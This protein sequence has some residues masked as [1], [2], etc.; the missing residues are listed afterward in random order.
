MVVSRTF[1]GSGLVALAALALPPAVAQPLPSDPQMTCMFSKA[2]FAGM[3]ESGSVTL[4]GAVNPANS[5]VNPG[6]AGPPCPF[7]LWADQMYLWLTG[8][9]SGNSGPITLFS[10]TFYA[11]SPADSTG[12]RS[13]VRNVA[14]APVDMRL[15]TIKPPGMLP[16]VRAR[17]G[18]LIEVAPAAAGDLAAPVVRLRGGGTARLGRVA[19][20]ASG[21]L[22]YFDSRGRRVQVRV[23]ALPRTAR[24]PALLMPGGARVPVLGPAAARDAVRARRLGSGGVR[25]LVDRNNDVIEVEPGGVETEEGQASGAVLISQ[26]LVDGSKFGSLVYYLISANDAYAYHRSAQGNAPINDPTGITFPTSLADLA[27]AA[28]YARSNGLPPIADPNALALEIKSSWVEASTVPNPEDYVQIQANLPVFDMTNPNMWVLKPGQSRQATMVMVGLHVVGSTANHGEMVWASFEHFGNAPNM[29]YSYNSLSGL[30]TVPQNTVGNW[31]LAPNGWTGPFNVQRA[32]W[33]PAGATPANIS[34]SPIGFAP[35]LRLAPWGSMPG[36]GSAAMNTDIIAVNN[37]RI[38]QLAPGDV[39]R[40]YFQ[41]GA[42]WTNGGVAPSPQFN[43]VNLL[44]TTQLANTTMETFVQGPTAG[45]P[46]TAGTNCFSCH[47]QSNTSSP[48]SVAVSHVYG[49]MYPVVAA[50]RGR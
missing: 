40:N 24:R 22:Q 28:N 7:F 39:R 21:A 13:F 29:A 32:T 35:V 2:A 17:S 23:A 20:T 36:A 43:A 14:G 6:A 4:N 37:S 44:G 26:N 49:V 18:H 15:R 25:V 47:N 27:P 30:R 38:G 16:L 19:R 8:P 42:V 5:T 11:V 31:L 50:K 34:G 41:L 1:V 9:A 33:N 10:P 3:F 12:R 46:A 45:P 48:A